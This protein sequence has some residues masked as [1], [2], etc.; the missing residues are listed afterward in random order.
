MIFDATANMPYWTRPRSSTG[1]SA[2]ARKLTLAER[3][4]GL[5][6][7]GRH[8]DRAIRPIVPAAHPIA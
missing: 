5:D 6:V 1:H 8:R 4:A 3:G 7:S 2:P